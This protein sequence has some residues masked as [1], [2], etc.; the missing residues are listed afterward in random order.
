MKE[1]DYGV[2]IDVHTDKNGRDHIDIYDRDPRDSDHTSIHINY[3]SDSG[4]GNIVDTTDG[5]KDTTDAS[6]F[7]TT[8]CMRHF[9][10]NFDDNCEELT[11][12]R[13]FRDKF[14]SKEDIDHYY[15]TAPVIVEAIENIDDNNTIYNFIYENVV[16]ACV[17][18][19]KTGDYEFAYNRYKNSVLSL[20]EEFARP[21][22]EEKL[23]KVLKLKTI[24]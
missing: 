12:L 15:K 2:H 7:L 14:V 10:S 18:A 8:A 20:E 22:L 24:K 3:D 1:N 21:A 23:V 5:S 17:S 19:I 6:C 13:S 16:N 4:N 9:A 11:I